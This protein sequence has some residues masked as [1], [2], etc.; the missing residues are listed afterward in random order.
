MK[1]ISLLL[2]LCLATLQINATEN[3]SVNE[4]YGCYDTC[5]GQAT[6]FANEYGWNAQQEFDY[7]AECYD[8]YCRDDNGVV[9]F[10]NGN[11]I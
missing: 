10:P 9:L 4:I 5:D 2:I 3:E 6:A 8:A 1:K 11:E 7:F